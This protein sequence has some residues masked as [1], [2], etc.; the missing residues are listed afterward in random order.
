MNDRNT[1]KR[2]MGLHFWHREE[3]SSLVSYAKLFKLMVLFVS[4][5]GMSLNLKHLFSS[6]G[7]ILVS[8]GE[9]FGVSFTIFV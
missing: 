3:E 5:S 1:A 6:F 4:H 8:I 9:S 2:G 7:R